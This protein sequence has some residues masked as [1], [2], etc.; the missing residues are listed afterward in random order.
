MGTVTVIISLPKLAVSIGHMDMEILTV[1]RQHHT[2]VRVLTIILVM[3]PT[4]VLV[5]AL[6]ILLYLASLM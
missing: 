5:L 3:V 4:A 1:M 2:T 6:L